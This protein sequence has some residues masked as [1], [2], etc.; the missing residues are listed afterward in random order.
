MVVVIDL[1]ILGSFIAS[2]LGCFVFLY[3]LRRMISKKSKAVMKYGS[4]EETAAVK[5]SSPVK[6]GRCRKA[7]DGRTTDVIIVGA[8]VA[9]AALAHTL[10][11]VRSY[12]NSPA[13]SSSCMVAFIAG[14]YHFFR[15][16]KT[17]IREFLKTSLI[18]K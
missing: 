13:F 1:Y 4:K 8:G 15:P 11:K 9:G 14:N 7:E 5:S 16:N 6:N 18:I 17:I 10:G 12:S 2:L 3:N